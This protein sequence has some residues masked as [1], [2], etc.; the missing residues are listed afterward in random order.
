MSLFTKNKFLVFL[1]KFRLK[2]ALFVIITYVIHKIFDYRD[3]PY[4]LY[5]Q[6]WGNIGSI[7]VLFGL[8]VRS[9]AAGVINKNKVLTKT[10][11]YHICRHPLYLGSLL[12][13]I[14]FVIIL[15]DWFL[16]VVLVFF[17]VFVYLPKIRREEVKLNDIFL[18]EYDKFK[19][20]TGMLYPKKLSLKKL[21]HSWSFKQW[22][23]HTEYNAW[24][25]A[26]VVSVVLE[27]WFNY[28]K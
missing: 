23:H 27:I 13:S 3:T 24:L 10:G 25:A 21:K 11:P 17:M 28:F 14:G 9:W 1:A 7:I 22:V 15:K 4:S 20:E 2:L 19:Q 6:G 16:W 26:I 8:I 12:M 18:G 5:K